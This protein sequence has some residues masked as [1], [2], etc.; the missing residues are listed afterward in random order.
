MSDEQSNDS[1]QTI[2]LSSND[3]EKLEEAKLKA[4]FPNAGRGPIS[5]H[6]VF[7]QKR[8]AK[9]KYFDS[10]DYQMAKQKSTAKPKPAGVLPTGDAIP[11]PETVP[12]RKTSIIQQKFNTSSTS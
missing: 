3:I 6:S 8:L 5:G 12:Q 2:E 7:L 4:K 1:P 11:T 10:G 9:G